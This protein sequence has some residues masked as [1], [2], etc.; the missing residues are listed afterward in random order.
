ML[1]LKLRCRWYSVM[2]SKPCQITLSARCASRARNANR[3]PYAESIFGDAVTQPYVHNCIAEV[4]EGTATHRYM[5]FFKRHRRL[6]INRTITP[7]AAAFRGDAIVMRIAANN[8][9]LVVNM[10]E[11]DTIISDWVMPRCAAN[12][13]I[14]Y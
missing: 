14:T 12:S 7:A 10:R 8:T 9:S 11:R 5:I 4:H 6:Q 13:G 3:Y 2:K 1:E